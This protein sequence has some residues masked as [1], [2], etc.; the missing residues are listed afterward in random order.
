MSEN[1]VLYLLHRVGFKGRM[2]GHGWRSVGSSWANERGFNPDAIELQLAHVDGS[3]R[4][5]YNRSRYLEERRVIL[6]AWADWLVTEAVATP[7]SAQSRSLSVPN[8]GG[9]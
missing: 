5:I 9:D 8:L 2:T 1:A 4:A 3:V 7:A 6:Q